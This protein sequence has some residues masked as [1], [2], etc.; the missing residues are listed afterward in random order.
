MKL[1]QGNPSAQIRFQL[2]KAWQLKGKVDAAIAGYQEVLQLQPDCVQAALKLGTL[3][4][5]QER[6]DDA[7]AVYSQ[8]LRLNPN[9]A[10]LH[11]NFIEALVRKDGIAVAF[12]SYQLWRTDEKELV[13]SP[14]DILCCTV[15]RNELVRLPYFLA[16]Y[17]QQGIDK[18]FIIDNDSTDDTRSYL[19]AQPDVYLWHSTGSF[20]QAN[21]G[22]VWFELLLRTYGLDRWCL[23]VD[24]D[25]ILYYPD[26]ETRSIHQLCEALEGQGKK[27][28]TA[29]L[30]DLYSDRAIAETHYT[31]GQN[32]LDLCPYFDRDFYHAKYEQHGPYRNQ[33]G[34]F[35]GVR[36]RVFGE[37]GSYYLSKVPLIQYS[38]DRVLTGGQHY[39]NC[40]QAEIATERGCLLHFKYFASFS[41]YVEREATRKEHYANGMQYAEYA[42]AIAQND[43]LTLYD[44][45]SSIALQ[46]SQQLV[47]LDI[48]QVGESATIPKV[49][50]LSIQPTDCGIGRILFYS[51]CPEIYGA[52]QCNHALMCGL[53][54]SG[55]TVTCAQSA[56]SH[57]LIQHRN[58]LGIQHLW[59]EDDNLYHPT[60][61]A[62]AFS[63]TAEAQRIFERAKPDLII[64][65]DGSPFSSLEAKQVAARLEIPYITL[66]HCVAL[67]WAQKFAS[68]LDRLPYLYEKARAVITVARE[69]LE[70]LRQQFKLPQN[71]GQVIYNGRPAQYFTEQ[72][73][74]ARDRLRQELNIPTEAV[75]CLTTA[76]MEN[77][78]GYQ[79]QLS[80]IQQ[81]QDSEI[82]QQLYFIWV[83]TGTLLPRLQAV[84]NELGVSE[85]I[86]F[87]GERSDIPDLLDAADIFILPSQFEGMPLAIMEAMA[88]G[89]PVIATAVSGIPEELGDT[90]KRL[91]DPN[92]APQATIQELAATLQ[93]WVG[94][95]TLRHAIGQAG[96]ERAKM[97]FTEERTIENYVTLIESTL[98]IE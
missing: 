26:C 47:E 38:L 45:N 1:Q 65:G 2:A 86:K 77:V 95:V 27:A 4:L 31:P 32:F 49:V 24:A 6:L 71:R 34:Y 69:N 96:K 59:L 61:P 17:R 53:V 30:L 3:L 25:E 76:R 52:A 98:L 57:H 35:G 22:S 21:F 41:S 29:V 50:P 97:L 14:D 7:I 16:Y 10:E 36:Q 74:E 88:K 90:G 93:T 8:S 94:D 72:N 42:K 78:K 33:I 79:Y 83:G 66:I 9:E 48:M 82:W 89:K 43:S 68:Y 5:E 12:E 75:V 44:P 28:M 19:L 40:P 62:R 37:S 39:T 56:A 15:A 63:N 73:L 20:N 92:I 55:Y 11:K 23:I 67:D 51:D 87:L 54:A 58:R 64:F 84:A 70:L 46:D 81:L 80:A 60:K 91:S 85:H 13:L 18:F